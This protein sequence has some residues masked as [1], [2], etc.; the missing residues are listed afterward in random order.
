MHID[1]FTS[2]GMDE[3]RD[4]D[5]EQQKPI[6][7]ITAGKRKVNATGEKTEKELK[8]AKV[9]LEELKEQRDEQKKLLDAQRELINELKQHQKEAHPDKQVR[10]VANQSILATLTKAISGYSK[11]RCLNLRVMYNSLIVQICTVR[12]F[13]LL[14]FAKHFNHKDFLFYTT[15]SETSR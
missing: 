14:N 1:E 13:Y 3:K 4:S 12:K 10:Q 8:E 11:L 2:Q 5:A 6:Q 7:D 15:E 9:L